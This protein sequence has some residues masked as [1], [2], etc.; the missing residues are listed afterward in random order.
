MQN[1]KKVDLI[2]KKYMFVDGMRE[3]NI[4]VSNCY[5]LWIFG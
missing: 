2:R 4:T 3:N 5:R 1:R